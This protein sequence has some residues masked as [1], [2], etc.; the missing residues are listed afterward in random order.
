MKRR[1]T[2]RGNVT[3]SGKTLSTAGQAS[4]HTANINLHNTRAFAAFICVDDE[5]GVEK[6]CACARARACERESTYVQTCGCIMSPPC[7]RLYT[8][9]TP[10]SG[11]VVMETV[12]HV[13]TKT[14]ARAFADT[15][16]FTAPSSSSSLSIQSRPRSVRGW[17]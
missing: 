6:V 11:R 4:T 5:L 8:S 7:G 2:S 10:S 13:L 9:T 16:T 12:Q 3:P 17:P 14:R 15:L 1:F